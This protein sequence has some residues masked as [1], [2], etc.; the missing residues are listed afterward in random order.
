MT[1]S[2]AAIPV[3]FDIPADAVETTSVDGSS[4]TLW[5]LSAESPRTRVNFVEEFEVPVYR[6]GDTPD[7]TPVVEDQTAKA[8]KDTK[9]TKTYEASWS[10]CSS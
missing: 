10:S 3:Y 1:P 7:A 6:T 2:G 8:T 4:G 9:I 5:V